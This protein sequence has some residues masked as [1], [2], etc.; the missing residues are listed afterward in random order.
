MARSALWNSIRLLISLCLA[1]CT[2]PQTT[3]ETFPTPIPIESNASTPLFCV[4]CTPEAATTTPS[5]TPRPLP[6]TQLPPSR[7]ATSR[8]S[9]TAHSSATPTVSLTFHV[10]WT[11]YEADCPSRLLAQLPNFTSADFTFTPRGDLTVIYPSGE[12]IAQN[13]GDFFA[14]DIET[15]IALVTLEFEIGATGP[16]GFWRVLDRDSGRE[17]YGIVEIEQ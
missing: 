3:E 13:Y 15:D 4:L 1:H 11:P 17:C 16:K 7:T 2:L 10:A 12:L 14:L 6:T 9:P 5:R 8:P